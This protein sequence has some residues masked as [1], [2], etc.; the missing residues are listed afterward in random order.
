MKA[1]M[2]FIL[3]EYVSGLALALA[4][5][6][7]YSRFD[8]ANLNASIFYSFIVVFFSMIVGVAL[9]GYVHLRVKNAKQLFGKAIVFSFLGLFLFLILYIVLNAVTSD[10]LPPYI[11]S[12]VLPIILPLTG[13][14]IGFNIIGERNNGRAHAEKQ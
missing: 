9:I 1:F 4:G 10:V 5:G 3:L 6:Y 8:E 2:I 14:V 11:S 12:I 13:A 7:I